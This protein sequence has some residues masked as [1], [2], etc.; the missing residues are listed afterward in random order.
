MHDEQVAV[1]LVDTLVQ[2]AIE[3]DASDIHFEPF[4]Q[5]LHIRFRVDGVLSPQDPIVNTYA[6]QIIMRLKVLAEINTAETRVPQDGKFRFSY[7]DSFVDVRVST[8]PSLHGEKIVARLLNRDQQ[9]IDL[10]R[11]GIQEKNCDALKRIISKPYG[12]FLVTGPTG[13][14][15]TTTLYAALSRLHTHD[16]NIVTLEDPVEYA[17]DGITQG[18]INRATGFTFDVG[19]RSVLRQ[20]PD[21]LLVGEIRDRQTARTAIEAALTGHLVLSTLH[22]NDAPSAIVRLLDMGIEPFLINAVLLGVL[23]QRLVRLLC[24]KCKQERVCTDKEQ[25][26][27]TSFGVT[28]K[29]VYDAHGCD[30]CNNTGYV[31][32]TGIFE[33]L[34][35]TDKLAQ[36][37]MHESDLEQLTVQAIADGTQLMVCDGLCKVASGQTSLAELLRVV[38][39]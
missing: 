24:D 30:A 5:N 10:D 33:L 18:Q 29:N 38:R 37:V 34:S 15:K 13:S 17:L 36:L 22:T 4:E 1:R 7:N 14:G 28:L 35:V 6:D 23:A 8:F 31:G 27:A 11:L 12:L 19:I 9:A 21:I 16:K 39:L 32:R 20:D 2:K 26:W 25:Q 3:C